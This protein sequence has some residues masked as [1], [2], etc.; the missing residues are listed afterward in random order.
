[1][2]LKPTLVVDLLLI[3]GV[4][5]A[6]TAFVLQKK[7]FVAAVVLPTNPLVPYHRHLKNSALDV[8]Q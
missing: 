8:W 7:A 5:F 1:L 4:E 3:V 2:V 6:E